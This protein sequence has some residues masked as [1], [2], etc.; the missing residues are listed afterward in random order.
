MID[1]KALVFMSCG[2][3]SPMLESSPETCTLSL[4]VSP[5]TSEA[6]GRRLPG[7]TGQEG[8]ELPADLTAAAG[9][10]SPPQGQTCHADVLVVA[11][12]GSETNTPPHCPSFQ[13]LISL[14]LT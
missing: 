12:Q 8:A 7:V 1:H 10:T 3:V 6:M 4:S 11:G 9:V 5:M 14:H 2:N 13:T